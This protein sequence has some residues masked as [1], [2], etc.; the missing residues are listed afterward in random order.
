MNINQH[1][2]ECKL[3]ERKG[4]VIHNANYTELCSQEGTYARYMKLEKQ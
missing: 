2:F 3:N 1:R 4:K